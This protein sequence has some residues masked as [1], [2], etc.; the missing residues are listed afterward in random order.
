MIRHSVSLLITVTALAAGCSSCFTG[1]ESTPRI[2]REDVRRSGVTVSREQTFAEQIT[3]ET[4][5]DWKPG[6][7][8]KVT[9]NKIALIFAGSPTEVYD[10]AGKFIEL[11]SIT[12]VNTVTGVSNVELKFKDAN[13]RP[14]VYMTD[15]AADD[16]NTRENVAI[17]FTVEMSVVAEAD[18]LLRGKTLYITTPMWYDRDG[19]MIN[20][21]RHIPVTVNR[22]LPGNEN[23]PL[24]VAFTP[25]VGNGVE[26]YIFMTYGKSAS[27]TRN[28]E[29]LFAFD[30]PRLRY[31]QITD[32]TWGL[33]VR[34]RVAEGM[35]RDEA[36]LALGTPASIDKGYTQGSLQMERWSYGD[37]VY[38]IFEEGVLI[39]Y[40]I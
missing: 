14:L 8:W 3:G 39:R 5:R 2:T 7:Q 13:G 18:S 38:L 21:L 37:G 32:E 1:I 24:C 4:P 15:V 30:N 10:L 27:S 16:W 22:V 20:G 12:P 40:R 33:I 34:S 11:E 9:D 6:K 35:N 31:P 19:R 25:S 26:C 29:R 28:F 36:K 23:Y 17:P